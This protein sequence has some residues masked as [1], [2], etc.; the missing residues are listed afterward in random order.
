MTKPVKLADMMETQPWWETVRK[1]TKGVNTEH[2]AS[3]KVRWGLCQIKSHQQQFLNTTYC[4][5]QQNK[6]K[7]F[8]G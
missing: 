1:N 6:T 4:F 2:S 7:A 3:F 8:W 5:L